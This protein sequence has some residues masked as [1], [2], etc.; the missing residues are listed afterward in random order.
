MTLDVR[1]NLSR[2][3]EVI[4]I[5]ERDCPTVFL[6]ITKDE[7]STTS[8]SNDARLVEVLL[9]IS[10]ANLKADQAHAINCHLKSSTSRRVTCNEDIIMRVVKVV[11]AVD[12]TFLEAN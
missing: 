9:M 1:Y 5:L 8:N 7:G 12:L 6:K 11:D 10:E 4:K 3:S 2:S